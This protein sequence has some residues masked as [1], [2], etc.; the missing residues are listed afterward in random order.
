MFNAS[1]FNII[2]NLVLN[3]CYCLSDIRYYMCLIGLF[4]KKIVNPPCWGYQWKI[5]GGRVKVVRILGGY[6]KNWEKN[7]DLEGQ[8]KDMKISRWVTVNLARNPGGSKKSNI[9]FSGKVYF[10]NSRYS[11]ILKIFHIFSTHFELTRIFLSR[12]GSSFWWDN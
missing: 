11:K 1:F 3:Y 4:Q 12:D 8:C 6:S 10:K 5:P 9:I 2:S 7:M